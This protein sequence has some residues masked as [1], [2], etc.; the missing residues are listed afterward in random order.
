MTDA[1]ISAPDD[2]AARLEERRTAAIRARRPH[3]VLA[4]LAF[5]A[6][7][8]ASWILGEVDVVE[9][10]TGLPGFFTYIHDTLPTVRA[11]HVLEDLGAWYSRIGIW[12]ALLWDTVLIGF[13]GTLLGFVGAFVLC[14]P[15]SRNLTRNWPIY[16]VTRRLLEIARGVPELV[17][18][19]ILV[20][21][22]GLGPFPG[23]LALAIHTTGALGKLFSEVNEN[24][25]P[26]PVEGAR[27]AGA[28]WVQA[29]RYAVV[30]QVL[31]NYA[32]Y[33]LLRFEINVR[34]ATVIGFV[35][36]GGIGQE[37]MFVFRQFLFTEI[38]AI[39]LLLIATV[40]VI[41]MT[42]ENLRHRLIGTEA[43][44]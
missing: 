28:S 13:L 41:D 25:D 40:M 24:V 12:L 7:F 17:Y 42:C 44:R 4:V 30:P 27:A 36:A 43:L 16:F 18:A 35:G 32:S 11:S 3:T 14:F 19:M 8:V 33:T 31:P 10:V 37:L 23:V 22:F 39:V 29:M 38:S 21:S 1:T 6:C 2:P 5:A 15:A 34:E 9:F 26:R 20:F